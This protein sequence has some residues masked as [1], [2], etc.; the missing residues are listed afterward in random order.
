MGIARGIAKAAK[1]QSRGLTG[2]RNAQGDF[3][4][5]RPDLRTDGPDMTPGKHTDAMQKS[6]EPDIQ[7]YV[8]DVK[9]QIDEIDRQL[10]EIYSRDTDVD[11]PGM[12][13]N[14]WDV[15]ISRL[16]N[17]KIDLLADLHAT[18]SEEG[19]PVPPELGNM[20][21]DLTS[22]ESYKADA[23]EADIARRI[24]TGEYEV[25]PTPKWL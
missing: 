17:E 11:T 25:N 6:V 20:L 19:V 12:S 16:E 3:I 14:D 4:A 21:S 1:A 13:A 8:D 10:D 2:N 5:E 23:Q 18:L 9:S 22:K 15:E 24:S 7:K